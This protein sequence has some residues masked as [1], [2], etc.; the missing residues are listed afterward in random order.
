MVLVNFLALNLHLLHKKLKYKIKVYADVEM[1]RLLTEYLLLL[2]SNNLTYFISTFV[3][4]S[5]FQSQI[6]LVGNFNEMCRHAIS[7]FQLNHPG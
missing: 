7:F 1:E 6:K 3:A 2:A 5:T 4:S